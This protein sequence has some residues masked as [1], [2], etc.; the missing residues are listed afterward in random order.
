MMYHLKALVSTLAG[1]MLASAISAAG[2]S[3][4]HKDE[5]KFGSKQYGY[6]QVWLEEDGSGKLYSKYSN[7]HRWDGDTYSTIAVLMGHDGSKLGAVEIKAGM[8]AKPFGGC[9]V[10]ELDKHFRISPELVSQISHIDLVFRELNTRDD[11]LIVS[12]MIQIIEEILKGETQE[13]NGVHR[14]V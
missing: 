8:S 2:V 12:A 11:Q 13:I 10:R 6:G 14:R 5:H 1:L 7:C 4:N 3:I 9:N